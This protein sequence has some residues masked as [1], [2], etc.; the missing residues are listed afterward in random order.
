ML[1]ILTL[2][3]FLTSLLAAVLG[4]G[5]GLLLMPL[6]ALAVPASSL[7]P[8]HASIQ[9]ASNSSRVLFAWQDAQKGLLIQF[10]PGCILGALTMLPILQ[11]MPLQYL[12]ALIGIGILWLTWGKS[13][14][15][16]TWLPA[17]FFTLG[18]A[19]GS[20]GMLMGATGPLGSALLLKKGLNR[21]QLVATN[22][23]FMVISHLVKL[24][25]FLPI[26]PQWLNFWPLILSAGC[27]AIAASYLGTRLR[28]KLPEKLFFTLFKILISLLALHML[29]TSLL[30]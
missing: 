14:Q 10:V 3:A 17:P 20:L 7:I 27:A 6:L 23:L 16:P 13:P 5:G 24:P 30:S 26:A 9:L 11:S 29:L 28:A 21:D 8:V 25:L 4:Q 1:I 15:L 22:A 18:L 12:P 2:C 19:Q